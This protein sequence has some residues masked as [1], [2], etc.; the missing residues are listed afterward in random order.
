MNVITEK[1]PVEQHGE[2]GKHG[3][4]RKLTTGKQAPGKLPAGK[5][6]SGRLSPKDTV[7]SY[8]MITFSVIGLVVFVILPLLWVM[9]YCLFSYKGFGDI[10]F[11]GLKNFVRVFT[12]SP[13]YW[14]AVRNTFVFTF[15][16][17]LVEIPL[18]LILAFLLT[19]KLRAV[20]FFRTV[21]FMP[22]MFS[23]A[24]IGVIFF[25]LFSS[26]NGVVNAVIKLFGGAGL[27]WFADG[28][29][30]MLVLMIA[31]IWQ[32]FGLNMLFFMTGLQS[33]P[34]D[35]YEAASIDGAGSLQKLRYIT[36]PRM[37]PSIIINL[38]LNMSSGLK[39]FDLV[40][41]ITNGGPNGA[42]ELINTMVFKQYGQ[43]L[44]GMSAAYGVIVFLIT[45]FFGVLIL[46]I[47]DDA[48][49]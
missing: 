22:S 8:L 43:K 16:K 47:R 28:T 23:V 30:A 6:A 3:K 39:T 15:G 45:A 14:L 18:A 29:H 11:V 40:Y 41:V 1:T 25:F 4:H 5:P 46:R 12:N 48:D 19:S 33:I 37:V 49:S 21:Y 26:Y 38:L 9:R 44:Y 35:L 32:N 20:N 36:L 17:L 13:K 2:H 10:S 31:S 7:Q 34:T 27:K 24:V 42:S